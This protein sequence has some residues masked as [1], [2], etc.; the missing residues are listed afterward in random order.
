MLERRY[1]ATCVDRARGP[2]VWHSAAASAADHVQ[3][4]ND[5]ARE[6]VCCNAGLGASRASVHSY[7]YAS[8]LPNA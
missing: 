2:T 8:A 7:E 6:A 4:S 1:G 5:L 3:K